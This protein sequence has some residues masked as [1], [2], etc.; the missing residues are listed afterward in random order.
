ML[1]KTASYLVK[2]GI[3]Q[4]QYNQIANYAFIQQEINIKI[5]DD[6][7][8]SYMAEVIEQCKTK[9]P[10]YGGIVEQDKL[11]ENLKQNCIPDGFENMEIS[12]YQDFLQKR[13]ELMAEKIHQYYDSL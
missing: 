5:R 1:M 7:P 8:A 12:D 2:N 13:R 4:S 10:V 11:S 9:Q 6:S 3:V